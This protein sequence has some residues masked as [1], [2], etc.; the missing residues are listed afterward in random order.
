VHMTRFLVASP[1]G[2]EPVGA[3]VPVSAEK[4]ERL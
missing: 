2:V 3:Q 1:R 4:S